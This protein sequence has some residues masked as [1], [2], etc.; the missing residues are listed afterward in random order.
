MAI[1]KVTLTVARKIAG[2]TQ[3]DLAKAIGVS[4]STILN[5]E[6]GRREPTISQAV[7]IGNAV[8]IPYD[9]I[10]FLPTNTV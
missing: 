2:M 1:D 5:W 3:N 9:N 7:A 8:G 6:K 10:I 4:E